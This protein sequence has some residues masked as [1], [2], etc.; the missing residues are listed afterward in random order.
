MVAGLSAM[1]AP[2][3]V[4]KA[5]ADLRQGMEGTACRTDRGRKRMAGAGML[6][7]EAGGTGHCGLGFDLGSSPAL[8]KL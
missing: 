4:G 2:W 3:K 7:L 6:G 1:A 5:R 8:P